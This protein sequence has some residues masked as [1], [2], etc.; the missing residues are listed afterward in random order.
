MP[1]GEKGSVSCWSVCERGGYAGRSL[2]HQHGANPFLSR[3]LGNHLSLSLPPRRPCAPCPIAIARQRR[4]PHA[5]HHVPPSSGSRGGAL[6]GKTHLQAIELLVDDHLVLGRWCQ[7]KSVSCSLA[8]VCVNGMGHKT[9]KTAG[10]RERGRE[11]GGFRNDGRPPPDTLS[12]ACNNHTLPRREDPELRRHRALPLSL[13][14]TS[15]IP[16]RL[17]QTPRL[18]HSASTA[19]H[20]LS[21]S[22]CTT[23]RTMRNGGAAHVSSSSPHQHHQPEQQ[24]RTSAATPHPPVARSCSDRGLDAPSAAIRVGAGIAGQ[25]RLDT[26]RRKDGT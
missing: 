17:R 23:K 25:E 10:K 8:A 15:G 21:S 22:P 24:L 9:L 2:S 13:T 16:L 18:W 12:H 11:Q 20:R 14:A 19:A 3:V 5:R 7:L 6:W 26:G 4:H 1:G